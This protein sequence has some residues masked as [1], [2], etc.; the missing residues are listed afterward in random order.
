MDIQRRLSSWIETKL[1][2]ADRVCVEGL[3]RAAMGHSAETFF[4]TVNWHD[5]GGDHSNDIVIRVRPPAPGLLE[6]YDLRRQF[7]VL[8]GLEATSVR[9]PRALWFEP[10]GT[11]LGQ[12]FYVMER[13][14]GTVY[15]RVLPAEIANDPVRVRRMCESLVD[16]VAAIHMVDL[17]ATGLQSIGNGRGYLDEEIA[18]WSGEMRRVQRGP[19]PALE[20]LAQVLREQLP[21]QCPSVTLVHGDAKPGNFA[22]WEGEVTA[23][24]DWEM[25]SIGDPL[26]DIGWAEVLWNTPGSFT[27]RPGALSADEMV[28]RW[29]Q[30]TGIRAE[31]RP[32]YRA[33]QAF[34]MAVILLVAGHLFDAG[35]T[36]DMRFMEMTYS[37]HPLTQLGLSQLGIDEP[38]EPGPVLPREDRIVAV[39]RLQDPAIH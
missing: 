31:H 35:H 37:I 24:L 26:A 34:K 30:L 15:E 32:W 28:S 17:G 16:Q 9:S 8:R 33:F 22:F 38:L 18:K 12:E 6:P 25:A 13:L 5:D 4:L 21:M 1:P 29:E 11:V 19:L 39:R 7:E 23:V 3:D 2:G 27:S 20:H 14:P 10:S 36:D